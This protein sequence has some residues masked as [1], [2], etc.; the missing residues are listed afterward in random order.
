[1]D[2]VVERMQLQHHTVVT[3]NDDIG[4]HSRTARRKADNEDIPGQ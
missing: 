1:M 2:Q 3:G 4:L